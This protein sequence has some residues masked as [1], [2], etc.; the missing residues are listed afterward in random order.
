MTLFYWSVHLPRQKRRRERG[1]KKAITTLLYIVMQVF[2]K[3]VVE[4]FCVIRL[5]GSQLLRVAGWEILRSAGFLQ[6]VWGAR[7]FEQILE[8]NAMQHLCWRCNVLTHLS[9]CRFNTQKTHRFSLWPS[10]CLHFPSFFTCGV[11]TACVLF[12]FNSATSRDL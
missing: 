9:P 1:S 11:R 6:N 7:N 2:P 3:S 12:I 10:P 8:S 5:V 4:L